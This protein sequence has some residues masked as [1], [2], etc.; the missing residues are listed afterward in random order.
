MRNG[1]LKPGI[2]WLEIENRIRSG[3]KPYV[4]SKDFD[5]SRQAIEKRARKFGWI[6]SQKAVEVAKHNVK[7]AKG[8][9]KIA[10]KDSATLMTK[11]NHVQRFAK[12]TPET[13]DAIL[14]LLKEGNPRMIAA[15]CAGVSLDSLNRWVSA[16]DN[17][18]LLVRQAESEAARFRLQ[19]IKKAGN[20]GDWKADS[21][22]LERTQRQ[23]FGN[24]NNKLGAMNLQ[25]NIMRDTSTEPVTIDSVTID[26]AEVSES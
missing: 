17:F 10:T 26:N 2:N 16:D 5:I 3:E 4:V 24:E 25:I 8:E 22:Y 20:R 14:E 23:I 6:R 15:Q 7:V 18:A 1:Q 12:D 19:N 21:W 13:K 9:I 11:R